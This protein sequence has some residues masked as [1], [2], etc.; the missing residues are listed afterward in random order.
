MHEI[1]HALGLK[2]PFDGTDTLAAQY[3]NGTYTVMSYNP[4]R[5][6]VLGPLDIAAI[7]QIYG[8]PTGATHPS[9]WSWDPATE[10]F[11]TTAAG[12]NQFLRG[13]GANDIVFASGT[14]DAVVTSSGDDIIHANGQPLQINTGAGNDR[15]YTGLTFKDLQFGVGGSGDFRY[16]GIG[17]SFQAYNNVEK[18]IF[19]DGVYDTATN[20]F[21]AAAAIT[22]VLSTVA[23]PAGGVVATGTTVTLTI[24]MSASVTVSGGTPSLTMNDG[25]IATYDATRSG[26]AALVFNHVI[27]SGQNA[28]ALAV[29]GFS[30]NGATIL[31]AAGGSADLTGAPATFTGLQVNVGVI[32]NLSAD[33]QL[34]LIYSGYFNRAAEAAGFNFW[35]GQNTLAKANGQS[36]AA[37][38]INVANSFTPQPETVALYPFLGTDIS[39][40]NLRDP[41]TGRRALALSSTA[42]TRTCSFVRPMP[43]AK[44]YWL[45]QLTSGGVVTLGAAILAISKRRDGNRPRSSY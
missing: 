22:K 28:A 8:T 32:D 23:S 38:L 4:P 45:N 17:S 18:L 37:I 31:D 1:G 30:A 33:Q 40:I 42:F 39:R 26:G 15:V 2:H 11:T 25:G 20:H 12:D 19:S 9:T 35:Q 27:Q 21:T 44:S 10:T 14:N 43:P 5:S 41:T 36:P 24:T 29:L 7:Q 3:D 34:E 16:I 6:Y 13:P